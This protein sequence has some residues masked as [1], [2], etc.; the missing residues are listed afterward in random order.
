MSLHVPSTMLQD[1]WRLAEESYPEEG[2]GL[3]LGLREGDSRH[4]R[5]IKPVDNRWEAEGRSRRY[6]IDPRDVLAAED[7]ADELGLEI[8]GVYHSHPD[9][10]ALPSATDHHFAV[11]WYSY[12][13]TS[14]HQGKA[15][16]SRVWRLD[17]ESEEMMEEQLLVGDVNESKEKT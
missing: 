17:E 5:I 12:L 13:I 10:P 3:L 15:T 4:A 6:Q 14:V 16:E 9:H 8:I 1:I 7:Q 2:A 11:P